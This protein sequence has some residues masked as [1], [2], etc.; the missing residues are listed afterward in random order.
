LSGKVA[1]ITGAGM[2]QG[3]VACII[4]A[5]E[6][7]RIIAVDIDEAALQETARIVRATGGEIA[8][9]VADVSDEQQVH[10]AVES[11]YAAFGALHVVYN[12]AGVLWRDRDFSVVD[13]PRESWDR[14]L[15][16]NLTGV[17]LVC[18]YA[19]PKLIAGG[20]GSIVN[21]GS[22]SALY[23]DTRPQD[24]YTSSKGAIISLTRSL[25]VQY[26]R[27]GIR[28][29]VI[30]PGIVDTPMQAKETA[31]PDWVKAVEVAIPLGR[32]GRPQDIAYAALYLASDEASWVTGAELVVDGG[33][34]AT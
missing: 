3:R 13:T 21:I 28:A 2:G 6:G 16:I 29:N 19:T 14:V 24:A 31:N 30:H 27:D 34:I 10:E 18:K 5:D 25:A 26:A 4:F 11:G 9:A 20:G 15:A 8:T 23:G 22:V 1:L 33:F 32:L 17:Y 12:N 7:A